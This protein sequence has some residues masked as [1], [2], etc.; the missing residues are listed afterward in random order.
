MKRWMERVWGIVRV[1]RVE[2]VAVAE[3]FEWV[4][5][6]E[7]VEWVARA[8][9]VEW[10]A[11]TEQAAVPSPEAYTERTASATNSSHDDHRAGAG[12]AR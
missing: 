4:A 6:T 7:R 8:E 9:K 1:Q 5:V 10:V 3:R 11:V 12:T 2:W